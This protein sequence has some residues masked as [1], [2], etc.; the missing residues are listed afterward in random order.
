MH[1]IYEVNLPGNEGVIALLRKEG[2]ELE[3]VLLHI[4][5]HFSQWLP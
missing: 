5:Q 1:I 2:F 4:P 3:P